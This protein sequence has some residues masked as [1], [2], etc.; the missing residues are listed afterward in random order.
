MFMPRRGGLITMPK[1]SGIND[2][3]P[4][5]WINFPDAKNPFSYRVIFSD[6]YK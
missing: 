2:H 3:A 4:E 1:G 6:L 5:R